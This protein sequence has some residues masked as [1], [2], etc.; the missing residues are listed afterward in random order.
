MRANRLLFLASL[1]FL[2][3]PAWAYPGKVVKAMKAPCAYGTGLAFDGTHHL[4][5]T[6]TTC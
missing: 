1:A 2:C 6:C 4:S 3:T 5:H